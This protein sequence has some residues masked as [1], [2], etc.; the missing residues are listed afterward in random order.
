V[1]K[2]K[3][4]EDLEVWQKSKELTMKVYELSGKFP[5][6]EAFGVTGQMRRAA[7]SVAANIAEGF[8]RYHYLDKAKF[9]LNAR[10]SL[11]ELKSHLLIARDLRFFN[12]GD[13]LFKGIDSLSVGL[14]NLITST[15]SM[16]AASL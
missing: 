9:Y 14:N 3:T 15:K 13:D 11:Y 4:F 2:I 1:G 5:R 7:L 10:G 16:R 12:E 6:E 8:G